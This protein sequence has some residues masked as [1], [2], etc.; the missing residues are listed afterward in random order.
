MAH[1][2]MPPLQRAAVYSI[3]GAL[4][5]SGCWWLC[6][7]QLFAARGQFGATPHPWQPPIL[8]L[9]GVIAILSMYL[10][11]WMTA[12]HILR[13]W[14]RRLRRLSGGVFAA[15]SALLALSGFALFF[16]SDD[17]WQHAAALTH[18]VLGLAVTLSGI[19]HAFFAS[20]IAVR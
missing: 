2:R 4:W 15:F 20:R 16:V 12:R 9:H 14:P 3:L 1:H 17:R 5:L 13:W 19:Q 18:D 8:L 7:D 11:G 6:L 10:F